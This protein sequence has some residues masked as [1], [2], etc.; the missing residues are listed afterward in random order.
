MND[1]A[2]HTKSGYIINLRRINV[3]NQNILDRRIIANYNATLLKTVEAQ[4]QSINH[5]AA[6][7]STINSLKEDVG[8]VRKVNKNLKSKIDKME[9]FHTEFENELK[10]VK[11]KRSLIVN[12]L[13]DVTS[14][15]KRSQGT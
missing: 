2:K 1:E 12:T 6:L 5:L 7:E 3:L 15:T 10:E 14:T 4:Q 9:K 13:E 8:A 11:R